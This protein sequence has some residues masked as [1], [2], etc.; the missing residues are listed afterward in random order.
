MVCPATGLADRAAS[1]LLEHDGVGGARGGG[2]ALEK[3]A[4]EERVGSGKHAGDALGAEE[5]ICVR[6]RG[7][8]GVAGGGGGGDEE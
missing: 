2:N 8:D 5:A 4:R 7:D 6:G 3:A 1:P